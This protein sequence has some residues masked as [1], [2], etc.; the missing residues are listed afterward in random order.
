MNW[1]INASCCHDG[2]VFRLRMNLANWM[3]KPFNEWGFRN[4]RQIYQ[5]NGG[6]TLALAC[7]A[8]P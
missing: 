4:I 7:R 6:P 8:T 1:K 2:R 3:I 5:Q